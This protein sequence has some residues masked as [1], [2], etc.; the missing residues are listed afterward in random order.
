MAKLFLDEDELIQLQN[1][2]KKGGEGHGHFKVYLAEVM[3]EYFRE[4][5]EKR[6]YYEANQDEVR[7]ILKNGA[8]KASQVAMTMIEKIR[9][10]TG[11]KYY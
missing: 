5:R 6:H 8:I 11:I 7:E 4:F 2:Y 9:S 10:V 1:R 3:W